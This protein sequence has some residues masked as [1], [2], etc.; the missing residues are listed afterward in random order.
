MSEVSNTSIT[1][2]S[3][4]LP[5]DIANL[6]YFHPRRR[7]EEDTNVVAHVPWLIF[8]YDCHINFEYSAS[9]SLFQ[10]LY[11]YFFKGP[12][13]AQWSVRKKNGSKPGARETIDQIKDYERGRYVTSIEALTRIAGIHISQ[14]HPGVHRLPVHMPDKARLQM[15]RVNGS[16][17]TATLL[18]RYLNRPPHPLLD[19]MT[20][21]EFGTKCHI[22]THDPNKPLHHLE[23]LENIRPRQPQMR[24]RFYEPGHVGIARMMMVYPRHGDVYYLRAILAHCPANSWEQLRTVDG[25]LYTTFQEAARAQGLFTNNDEAL[26]V[27][28]E[29]L[30][31]GVAPS[32][33]RWVFAVLASEGEPVITLWEDYEADLSADIQDTMLRT[34]PSPHPSAIRNNTLLAIQDILRGLGK[35]MV[36]VGLPEPEEQQQEV[37]AEIARW[38]GDPGN[39][40]AF[41]ASLTEDQVSS[42]YH[43]Q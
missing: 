18:T 41:S 38:G 15:K 4:I 13:E 31:F 24:I 39:L 43:N 21:I 10:Y 27:F 11:K 2:R 26:M 7:L 35:K 9:V 25:I 5:T 40:S 6:G 3:Q 37:D 28:R 20:Y 42:L 22:V 36:D 1:P 32:Q 19:N 8:K 30:Q 23:I 29:L 14:K 34:N 33:L 12:D 16:Q 17:S